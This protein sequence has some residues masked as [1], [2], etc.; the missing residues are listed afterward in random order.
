MKIIKTIGLLSLIC[1]TF[2]YTEKIMDMA[3]LQDDIM[4]KLNDVKDK[5]YVEPINAKID[6]DYIIPGKI[7]KEIDID[8]SYSLMKK[9]GYF[10]EELIKYKEIYPS[11][12]IYNNYDK[13]IVNGNT[14]NKKV[15]LIFIINNKNVLDNILNIIKSKNTDITFFIDS[16]FLNNNIELLDLINDYEIYNY[17]NNGVYTMDNLIIFNNIIKNKTKIDKR[18]CLFLK[19]DVDSQNNCSNSKILSLIPSVNGDYNSIKNNLSNGNIILI[20]NTYELNNIIDFI[21]SKGYTISKLS[22]VI[23]E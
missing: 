23:S 20:N 19:E 15:S 16:N 8:K 10:D 1:F 6:G 14:Y 22:Q 21:T 5:Y 4:I 7:G 17:G 2:F 3:I 18:F 9:N 13:Y 12:S 11:I